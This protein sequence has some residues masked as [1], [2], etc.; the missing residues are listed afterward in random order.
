MNANRLAKKL[1]SHIAQEHPNKRRDRTIRII[2]RIQKSR[3]AF[4]ARATKP[5]QNRKGRAWRE[6]EEEKE[7][8]GNKI[9]SQA[10]CQIGEKDQGTRKQVEKASKGEVDIRKFAKK[11]KNTWCEKRSKGKGQV[12]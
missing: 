10:T 2:R 5:A 1:R 7:S 12:K 3:E 8:I 4:I 11:T 9:S 6:H